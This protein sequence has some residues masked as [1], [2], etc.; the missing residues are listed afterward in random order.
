MLDSPVADISST[1]SGPFAGAVT[2][3]LFL[4]EFVSAETPCAHLDLFA[5]AP[6]GKPGRPEGGAAHALG[7]LYT[8]IERRF[9]GAGD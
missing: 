5:W 7:A 9:G 4:S 3:A 1:G 8:L 6:S 2:A